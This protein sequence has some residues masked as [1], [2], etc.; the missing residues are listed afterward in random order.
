MLL[1][2][3]NTSEDALKHYYGLRSIVVPHPLRKVFYAPVKR[4]DLRKKPPVFL[5]L[6][7][8]E[9]RKGALDAV[10]AF[11]KI[12][13]ADARLVIVG[14]GNCMTRMQQVVASYKMNLRV[15]FKGSCSAEEI[16]SIMRSAHF[17]LLP[18]Y[19]DTGPTSL[20]EAIA[21]GLFPICY[22]NSG[23]H[24]YVMRYGCGYLCE[25]GKI[26]ALSKLMDKAILEM[27]L[28]IDKG[29]KAAARIQGDLSPS[30][31]WERLIS[32]YDE[33]EGRR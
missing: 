21:C 4:D 13:N 25:T 33:I 28:S 9:E 8:L 7:T 14:K 31:I 23:P 6:G 15:A 11:A 5:F 27:N 3:S 1:V 2:E 16:V 19:G 18:S 10:K 29:I 20:K 22:D 12:S 24:E 17:Y 26:D 32:V 30:A